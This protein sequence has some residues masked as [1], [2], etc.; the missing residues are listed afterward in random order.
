MRWP[1]V[2]AIEAFMRKPPGG[3]PMVR[4]VIAAADPVPG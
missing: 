3:D 2:T 4:S 1:R